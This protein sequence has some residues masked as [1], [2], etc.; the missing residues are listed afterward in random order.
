MKIETKA[1]LHQLIDGC[2]DYYSAEKIFLHILNTMLHNNSKEFVIDVANDTNKYI[3]N[4][5]LNTI[6]V[7]NIIN[8]RSKYLESYLDGT[9]YQED[10][11][12]YKDI[13][14][15]HAEYIKDLSEALLTDSTQ[16]V[17]EANYEKYRI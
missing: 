9:M 8:E 12:E 16:K 1:D 7:C 10:K 13:Q 5:M 2:P 4:F 11:P 17:I 15:K 3:S 6:H 14:K